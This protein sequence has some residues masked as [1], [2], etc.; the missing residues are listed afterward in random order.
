MKFFGFEVVSNPL[1]LYEVIF[2]ILNFKIPLI[3]ECTHV[4]AEGC[5]VCGFN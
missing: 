5:F 4:K 1:N 2:F 3:Y